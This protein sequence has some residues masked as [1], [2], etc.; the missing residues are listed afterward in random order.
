MWSKPHNVIGAMTAAGSVD[1]PHGLCKNNVLEK[2]IT[3][4]G[5][6]LQ[7]PAGLCPCDVDWR[8]CSVRLTVQ[9]RA[10]TYRVDNVILFDSDLTLPFCITVACF[11]QL[12]QTQH[13]LTAPMP[14]Y[15]AYCASLASKGDD[16]S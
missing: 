15:N 10:E 12:P 6:N 3:M 9:D 7:W 8:C 16:F 5:R 2:I 1:L 4:E 14:H 11:S 13:C